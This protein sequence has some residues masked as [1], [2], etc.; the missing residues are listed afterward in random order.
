MTEPK[1]KEVRHELKDMQREHIA[2]VLQQVKLLEQTLSFFLGYVEKENQLPRS[3]SGYT[4]K[5]D[6]QTQQPYMVGLVKDEEK[7]P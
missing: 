5:I 3:L 6:E 1:V 2:P 4:L 7:E